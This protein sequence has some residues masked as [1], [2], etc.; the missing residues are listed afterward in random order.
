[1]VTVS[2]IHQIAMDRWMDMKHIQEG[3]G[4]QFQ[5]VSPIPLYIKDLDTYNLSHIY[6]ILTE[7][8]LVN[9]K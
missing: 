2:A 9:V 6:N 4:C 1:M 8:C 3:E 5:Y 7:A